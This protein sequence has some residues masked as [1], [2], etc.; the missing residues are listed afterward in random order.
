MVLLTTLA[1]L[2]IGFAVWALFSA[3]S[4]ASLTVHNGTIETFSANQFSMSVSTHTVSSQQRGAQ[5]EVLVITYNSPDRIVITRAVP[6]PHLTKTIPENETATELAQY[7][8]VTAGSADWVHNGSA[9]DRTE[10][11]KAF[12]ARQ[13]QPNTLAGNVKE[14]AFIRNGYLTLLE[15]SLHA[16]V[17][18]STPGQSTVSVSEQE[19]LHLLR[20]NGSRTPV[21]TSS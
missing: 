4:T 18:S 12:S 9:F 6:R 21:V 16:N 2:T 10:T 17:A 11:I 14:T 19:T 5:D 20:I 7:A 15:L 3:P 13:G 1:V 8:A